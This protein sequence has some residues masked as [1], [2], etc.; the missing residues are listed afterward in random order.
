MTF[1][2]FEYLDGIFCKWTKGEE[3]SE[4]FCN[5]PTVLVNKS[6]LPWTTDGTKPICFKPKYLKR[7]KKAKNYPALKTNDI[8]SVPPTNIF[9][10]SKTS[11]R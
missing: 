8:T 1:F 2:V 7:K 9:S 10:A 6:S 5:T 4:E 11:V 3:N